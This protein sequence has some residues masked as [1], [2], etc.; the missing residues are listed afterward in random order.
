[1]VVKVLGFE[2]F[3]LA[4][5]GLI[6]MHFASIAFGLCRV[7]VL[8][9]VAVMTIVCAVESAQELQAFA[10]RC[11]RGMLYLSIMC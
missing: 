10:T 8:P 5:P 1:M 9:S 7:S 11:P 6:S 3:G 4:S 2:G